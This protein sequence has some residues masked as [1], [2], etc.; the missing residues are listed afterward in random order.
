MLE[1]ARKKPCAER[2]EWV[3]S[4][5]Q[6]YRSQKRF[7]LIVMTGHA[8][9]TLLTDD[10]ILATLDTMRVHLNDCGRIAFETRN[11]GVDW[12]SEWDRRQRSICM[13][14]GEEVIETLNILEKKGEF[15]SFQ[16]SYRFRHT[17]LTTNSTLRF[18]SREHVE[19]LIARAKL[20][21]RDVLGDWDA[22]PFNATR[23]QEI[24][25]LTERAS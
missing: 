7:D 1:I 13:P 4:T 9:Q 23:S 11:P 2:V 16:T 6:S 18:P 24:I 12:A 20:A 15:I 25:F 22:T 5:A 8:F 3:E 10:D 17:T 19:S 14:N 21:V